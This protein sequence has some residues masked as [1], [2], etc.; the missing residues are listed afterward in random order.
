MST[1][2]LCCITALLLGASVHGQSQTAPPR[3]LDE[4][5]A[6]R[7]TF[8]LYCSP[9]HGRTGKGDGPVGPALTTKPA[10]LSRLS[11]RAG[12]TY[13]AERIQAAVTGTNRP[14]AAHG[15]T[16]MPVWGRL[17]GAFD[18]DARAR[19]RIANVV[20]YIETLQERPG[21]AETGAELFHTYCASCHGTRGRGDGPVAGQLRQLPPDLTT[22]T[23]RNG[24]VFPDERV[25]QIVDGR[26]IGAHGTR[27]MPVWGDAFR[28][29]SGLTP[30][31][32]ASRIAA[33][34]AYLQDIQ[35]RDAR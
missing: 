25:R 6:G 13:P 2:A 7:D 3:I 34:V 4:S 11:E 17:F 21:A 26:G 5:V 8:Q 19:E 15:N 16:D 22:F 30:E 1:R 14:I 27:E 12:G 33:I 10:D 31:G 9:C 35:V 18:S 23:R 20:R 24:G 32:V 29:R 28:A